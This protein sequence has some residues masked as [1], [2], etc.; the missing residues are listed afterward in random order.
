MKIKLIIILCLFLFKM[1]SF[2]ADWFKIADYLEL[3]FERL[4]Y[5][6]DKIFVWV[7]FDADGLRQ[8]YKIMIP[9]ETKYIE[10]WFIFSKNDLTYLLRI[11][12]EYDRNGNIVYS[13]VY[14]E[15][16]DFQEIPQNTA[17][18][19]IFDTVI[20]GKQN[21]ESLKTIT[22]MGMLRYK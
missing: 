9:K 5:T 16:R 1:P 17:T 20:E 2:A 10:D 15:G 11:T 14:P 18:M 22:K 4:R 19:Y 21:V 8:D 12:N 13:S 7:K 3:D 6:Q